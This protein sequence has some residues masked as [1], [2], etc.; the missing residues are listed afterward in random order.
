MVLKG[1]IATASLVFWGTLPVVA[2]DVR[3]DCRI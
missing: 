1:K 3:E 2:T